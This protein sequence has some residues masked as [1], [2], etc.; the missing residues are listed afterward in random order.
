MLLINVKMTTNVVILMFI[1][2]INA[3]FESLKARKGPIVQHFSFI[4]QFK[5]HAQFR[6]FMLS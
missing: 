5:F 6:N 2:M 3:A 1:S 4:K